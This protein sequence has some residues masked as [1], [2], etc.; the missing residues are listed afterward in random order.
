MYHLNIANAPKTMFT[1]EAAET[2][3]ATLN[4]GEEDGLTYIVHHDPKGTGSSFIEVLDEDGSHIA[5]F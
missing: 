2:A 3:A 4:E 1:P 5:N